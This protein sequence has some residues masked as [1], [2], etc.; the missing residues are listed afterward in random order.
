MGV[1]VGV[2]TGEGQGPFT[3]RP[4]APLGQC[5]RP[6]TQPGNDSRPGKVHQTETSIGRKLGQSVAKMATLSV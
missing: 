1:R 4:C 5:V 6:T 3:R 2:L